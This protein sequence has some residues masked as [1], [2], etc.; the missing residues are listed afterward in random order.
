MQGGLLPLRFERAY[1]SESLV[2]GPFGY[3]WTHSYNTW[4]SIEPPDGP[5]VYLYT[6]D[7]A[8][9]RF[10][11]QPDGSYTAAP[12]VHR[13]LVKEPDGSWTLRLRNGVVQRF[14]VVASPYPGGLKGRLTAIVDRHGNQVSLNYNPNGDL[15]TIADVAGRLLSFSYDA[16]HRITQLVDPLGRT[17]AYQ[18][19]IKGDLASVTYPDS[20]Q[21]LYSYVYHQMVYHNDPWAPAGQAQVSYS[22]DVPGRGRVIQVIYP[23]GGQETVSYGVGSAVYSDRLGRTRTVV[24][25]AQSNVT[26][27]T[28]ASSRSLVAGGAARQPAASSQTR[29]YGYD[30]QHNVTS[31]V[32][33]NGHTTTY[34]YDANGNITSATDPTGHTASYTW[35]L[36]TNRLLQAT[37]RLGRTT[38]YAYNGQGDLVSVMDAAGGVTSYSYAGCCLPTAIT[39][40]NGHSTQYG[41]DALGNRTSMTDASG[42]VTSFTH[43]A[44]GRRLSKTDANSHTTSYAYDPAGRL[45][46]VADALGGVI[47]YTYD[48]HGNRLSETDANGHAATYGYNVLD[49]L[50]T[51][52]DAL[53]HAAIY[54][55]DAVGNRTSETDAN[56]HTTTY[57]Y[58]YLDRLVTVTDALGHVSAYSYDP[59][60]NRISETDANGHTTAYSYDALN[61]LTTITDALGHVTSYSYDAVDNRLSETDANGHTTAYSYD[62]LNRQVTITDALGHVTSYSYDPVGNRISQTDANGHTTSYSYDALDR[63]ATVTDALGHVTSYSYDPV[64]NRISQTDANGHVM[65]YSYD[66]LN[67][68]IRETDA[69]GNVTNYDYDPASNR[70]RDTAFDGNITDYGYD[71]L[72]R[73][74][75]IT[76]A[77]GFVTSYG[78]DAVGNRITETDAE[79][80]VTAFAYD[81]L[82]YAIVVTDA[83]GYETRAVYDS[84]GNMMVITDARGGSTTYGYDDVNRLVQETYADGESLEYSYDDVGNT[85]HIED[86]NSTDVTFSYDTINRLVE[87]A[88]APAGGVG[89]TTFEHYAYDAV[90]H[91]TLAQDDDSVVSWE[92]DAIGQVGSTTQ[93][94]A[95]VSYQY[96]AAGNRLRLTY[97]NGRYITYQPDANDRIDLIKEQNGQ[98]IVDYGYLGPS[99]VASRAFGNGTSLSVA[100]DADRRITAYL[101]TTD[102]PV[103]F[104][105]GYDQVGN[106]RYEAREHEDGAGD[107][108]EY[109]AVSQ[110]IQARYG[111]EDPQHGR[112]E[113]GSEVEYGYDAVGNRTA[114]T[115]TDHVVTYT[116]NS[117]NE[118]EAVDNGVLA[119]DRNG[120]LRSMT[121]QSAAVCAA[122]GDFDCDA[123]VDVIDISYVAE[124]WHASPLAPDR[125]MDH[126]NDNDVVDIQIVCAQWTGS[127]LA[128]VLPTAQS[129]TTGFSESILLTDTL[130]I[131]QYDYRDQLINATEAMTVTRDGQV[132]STAVSTATFSYDALG[133]RIAK[134]TAADAV[135]YLYDFQEV[136]EEREAGSVVA[137]YVYGPVL[138][139]L[140]QMKRGE[141]VIY[142]H[143]NGLGSI[144]HVTDEV[145]DVVEQYTYDVYGQPTIKTEA[146]LTLTQ[147]A[148]GNSYLFTG[149]TYDA[150][151]AL[152]YYR[153]RYYSPGLG[154]FLQRDPL[155]YM[156]GP[157]L[158]TYVQNNPASA[159][160]P[161]GMQDGGKE[162]SKVERTLRWKVPCPKDQKQECEFSVTVKFEWKQ[163]ERKGKAP[164]TYPADLS[165]EWNAV[166]TDCCEALLRISEKGEQPGINVR[167][168]KE[169]GKSERIGEKP[170]EIRERLGAGEQPIGPLKYKPKNV[171]YSGKNKGMLSCIEITVNFEMIC[172]CKKCGYGITKP[173]H[174]RVWY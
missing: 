10:D 21:A 166:G 79:G 26:N 158:Y 52:T 109:D 30:A 149:R 103:G 98:L 69:V 135:E 151:T 9:L 34:T 111:L 47:S 5:R 147:S 48:A 37:D 1:N 74:V 87:V 17:F 29:S 167:G 139:E 12:G 35:N 118:Y 64:G 32:D 44:L 42:A 117:V 105:Y 85:V 145:G 125:D 61:R 81:A 14:A 110:L 130:S 121:S 7:G 55:Y 36:T 60:G 46:S 6:H 54:S 75:E 155:G 2:A 112:R 25:D 113:S 71:S 148:V 62:A 51:R 8:V 73:L 65:A 132:R 18:Y 106:R 156:D 116:S 143:D 161:F 90:G 23:D 114:M 146:G 89:G 165:I 16:Q 102:P 154:R 56:G 13:T 153:A 91:L 11:Q 19:S 28:F 20:T 107:A 168:V 15:A 93:N 99:L 58:D 57:G 140:L 59:V 88:I 100:Y 164:L 169:K 129:S 27:V 24:T 67:R 131:Y 86:Q 50:V 97:P 53:G 123:D 94:G 128:A 160:D 22:Y 72:N 101:H 173:G 126:D 39:D 33:A 159:R 136:I 124:A 92:Y 152:Y 119:Y 40:A 138:D 142:Y 95:S 127:V 122:T 141:D 63:P 150:E 108:Y 49:R 144:T 82:G 172:R 96:D 66:S 115:T 120:N 163:L 171:T 174:L 80:H 76:D 84:V 104:R 3:G 134:H 70:I 77:L 68:L 4:L 137:Q 43:D 31:A 38:T 45:L 78:Y 83:L 157:N 133:R 41:Y 162:P 170:S